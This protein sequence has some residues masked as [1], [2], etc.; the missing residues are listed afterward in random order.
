MLFYQDND[1]HQDFM[2]DPEQCVGSAHQRVVAGELECYVCSLQDHVEESDFSSECQEEVARDQ[3]R[4]N[5]DYRCGLAASPIPT[6]LTHSCLPS[7][8]ACM[9]CP[10]LM[11]MWRIR[12]DSC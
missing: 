8:L 11:N 5:Q 1:F 12:V 6:T 2:C 3:V 4:S 9:Q 10:T 7:C